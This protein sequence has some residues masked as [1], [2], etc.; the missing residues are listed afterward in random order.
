MKYFLQENFKKSV[1][2]AIASIIGAGLRDEEIT[3]SFAKMI[4]QK[5]KAQ[6]TGTSFP[7][8][9]EKLSE[10]INKYDRIKKIHNTT[11]LSDEP[12]TPKRMRGQFDPLWFFGNCISRVREKPCFL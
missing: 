4:H 2:Y 10:E 7:L 6:E 3:I 9:A 8:S 11:S 5:I 1:D 12:L